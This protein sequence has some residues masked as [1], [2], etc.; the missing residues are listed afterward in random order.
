MKSSIALASSC[1]VALLPIVAAIGVAK[2]NGNHAS[3]AM[4][5]V[6]HAAPFVEEQKALI[7]KLKY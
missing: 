4:R 1:A 7:A 5:V 2:I 3:Q 6:A